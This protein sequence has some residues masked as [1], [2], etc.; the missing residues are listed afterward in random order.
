MN[1]QELNKILDDVK[2]GEI[3]QLN[4][5][6]KKLNSQQLKQIAEVLQTNTTLTGLNI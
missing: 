2:N 3:T 4:L 1:Q 5:S 6:G